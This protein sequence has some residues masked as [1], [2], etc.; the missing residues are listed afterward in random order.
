MLNESFCLNCREMRYLQQ[1]PP[2][3]FVAQSPPLGRVAV[4]AGAQD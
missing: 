2:L 3:H 1:A 4:G